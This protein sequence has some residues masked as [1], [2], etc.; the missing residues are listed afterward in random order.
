MVCE[1]KACGQRHFPDP[2]P[3]PRRATIEEDES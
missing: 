3:E 2:K 1:V